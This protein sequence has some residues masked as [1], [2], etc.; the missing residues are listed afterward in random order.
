MFIKFY[1]GRPLIRD[2]LDLLDNEEEFISMEE[3]TERLKYP[4]I[5]AVR[6]TC[7]KLK[8]LIN[9]NYTPDALDL[10]IS[11]RGGVR[12]IRHNTGIHKLTT[13]VN[14]DTTNFPLS[15]QLFQERELL[16]EEYCANNF[17]S[18]ST[19]FRRVQ[20]FN[21]FIQNYS[22]SELKFTLSDYIRV[23]GPESNIRIYYYFALKNTFPTLKD[24]TDAGPTLH[25][26]KQILN[27]CGIAYNHTQLERT[28]LWVYVCQDANK[29]GFILP[30]DDV[31]LK[32][33]DAFYYIKKP[34]FLSSWQENEWQFFLL[35]NFS[36]DYFP[37][38]K[39]IR[40]KETNLFQEEIEQWFTAFSSFFF[41]LS[42]SQKKENRLILQKQFLYHELT[43]FRA[44][45]DEIFEV[46]KAEALQNNYPF[47]YNRFQEFWESFTSEDPGKKFS[48]S[49]MKNFSLYN[50]VTIAGIDY[51]MPT[52]YIYL[53]T[54]LTNETNSF[55][56]TRIKN[57]CC[58]YNLKFVDDYQQADLIISSVIFYDA[59][60]EDQQIL[61]IRSSLQ[62]S[63]LKTISHT[64]NDVIQKKL[65]A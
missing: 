60:T 61:Y 8:E 21:R 48:N 49:N 44:N 36:L 55:I 29:R 42:D 17:L 1:N 28:A 16:S 10:I 41:P 18:H 7:H 52:V 46:P 51:F 4:S 5:H 65:P 11:T 12:L 54:E 53:L 38:D 19:L 26:S 59:I 14:Q 15:L 20:T 39:T 45:V 6:K 23:K 56:K 57:Y 35:V 58:H 27:Y 9:K 24:M 40:V 47:F 25:L 50:C 33:A 43:H 64:I 63:D 30:D 22:T 32:N 34:S 2:I 3:I 62:K 31:A 37:L 13:A